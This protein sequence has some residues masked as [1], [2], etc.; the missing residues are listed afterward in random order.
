MEIRSLS[1]SQYR[2]T[3]IR[4]LS[5]TQDRDGE[6]KKSVC[7]ARSVKSVCEARSV[8]PVSE[9]RLGYEIKKSVRDSKSGWRVNGN[10]FHKDFEDYTGFVEMNDVHQ[11][12]TGDRTAG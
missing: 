2:S 5:A 4:S 8:K 9:S 7:E 10:K 1:A 6:I 11:A 12:C 3:K